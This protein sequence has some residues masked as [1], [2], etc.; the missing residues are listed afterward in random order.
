MDSGLPFKKGAG[1]CKSW[2]E[3][4]KP[5]KIKDAAFATSAVPTYFEPLPLCFAE[6]ERTLIDGGIFINALVVSAY[7]EAQRLIA[8]RDE[9]KCYAKDDIFV[10]SLGTG[11]FTAGTA[12]SDAKDWGAA[13]WLLELLDY[14][15][16]S[17][18]AAA[19]YQ[20]ERFLPADNYVR[21]Q[22]R[23]DKKHNEMDNASDDNIRYLKSQAKQ[24]I[25]NCK[26]EKL[27]CRLKKRADE[28]CE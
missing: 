25:D 13:R 9:Y 7:A 6:K 3:K 12:Y 4:H 27:Y 2:N 21:L 24:L 15:S 1:H 19:H 16:H 5:I 26:F 8:E 17:G 23:L 28:V 11:E 22:T 20:M 10:V 18:P 14:I